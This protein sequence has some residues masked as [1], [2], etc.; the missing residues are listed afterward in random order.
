MSDEPI[1]S[2]NVLNE[3]GKRDALIALLRQDANPAIRTRTTQVV[4][5]GRR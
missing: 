3:P 1:V 5:E 4:G 2:I